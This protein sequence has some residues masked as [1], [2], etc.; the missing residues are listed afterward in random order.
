MEETPEENGWAQPYSFSLCKHT[1]RLFKH[2]LKWLHKNQA[3]PWKK[4]I[5]LELDRTKVVRDNEMKITVD[6]Y[7]KEELAILWTQAT[8][9]ERQLILLA[10]NCAFS[11]SEIGTLDWDMIV[12]DYI[13]RVR[14]KTKVYGE[15]LLWDITKISIG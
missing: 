15:F 8:F 12:G 9:F 14:P 13:K 10:L 7:T 2:F 5:E 11:I 6:V 1:I 3:F 4:P